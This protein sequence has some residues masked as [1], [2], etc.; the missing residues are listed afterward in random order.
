[1][2]LVRV[3]FQRCWCCFLKAN[4]PSMSLSNA[5]AR[6]A[7]RTRRTEAAAVAAEATG[8]QTVYSQFGWTCMSSV[9]DVPIDEQWQQ[10]QNIPIMIPSQHRIVSSVV[11]VV[12]E[13]SRSAAESPKAFYLLQ[14]NNFTNFHSV[15]QA[16]RVFRQS[17]EVR[18]MEAGEGG[19][20][21]WWPL[22]VLLLMVVVVV[23][24]QCYH[25]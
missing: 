7:S 17:M 24:Y 15:H 10:Q 25:Y 1:M 18:K 20:K 5:L 16:A 19:K 11:S 14:S 3:A 23:G 21:N 6:Y 9:A 2:R 8:T 4:G 13:S 12:D 22:L